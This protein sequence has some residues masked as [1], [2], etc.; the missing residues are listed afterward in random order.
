MA[1]VGEHKI[2]F[3]MFDNIDLKSVLIVL[4][5][6]ALL[7]GNGIFG[8]KMI[9]YRDLLEQTEQEAEKEHRRLMNKLS[10]QQKI[11]SDLQVT[12]DSLTV[13]IA[14]NEVLRN[15]TRKNTAV[16]IDSVRNLDREGLR[17]FLT[18]RYNLPAR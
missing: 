2:K 16:R 8:K 1:E 7:A 14:V 4:G 11:V 13:E 6:L 15:N 9:S 5:I 10:D 3:R 18:D 12:I 17:R